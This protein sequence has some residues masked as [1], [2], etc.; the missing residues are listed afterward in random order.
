MILL[1]TRTHIYTISDMNRMERQGK[2]IE[3]EKE[4]NIE[5]KTDRINLDTVFW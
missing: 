5:K 3:E 2:W 1:A 4:K